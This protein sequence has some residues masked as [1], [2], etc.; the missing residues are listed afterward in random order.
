MIPTDAASASKLEGPPPRDPQGQATGLAASREVEAILAERAR[1]LAR[2]ADDS[3]ESEA[4]RDVIPFQFS[5][6]RYAIEAELVREVIRH[7]AVTPIPNTPDFLRG[8]YN[9]RGEILAAM[10]LRTFLNVSADRPIGEW[11]IVCGRDRNEFGILA[12]VVLEVRAL[13]LSAVMK[14]RAATAVGEGLI[15]GVTADALS[16]LD[17][18][19]LMRDQRLYVTGAER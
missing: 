10:D 6:E 16:L 18:D 15:R 8:I 9:L 17:G 1:I 7:P 4:T 11:L 13:P 3:S 12:D 14:P 19:A 2:P 5:D